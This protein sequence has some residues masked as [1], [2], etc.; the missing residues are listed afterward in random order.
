MKDFFHSRSFK[1]LVAV[2]FILLGLM[3]Y[4][5]SS[6]NSLTANLLGF[7]STPMQ[8]VSTVITNNAVTA[9]DTATRSNEE[10]LKEIDALKKAFRP[11]QVT[12]EAMKKARHDAIFMHCLPAY[13]G[14][15]VTDEVMECAQSVVWDQ[16]ENRMHSIKGILAAVAC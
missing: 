8:K 3:L 6:G 11:Y 5:A 14:V 10:L 9:T 4:T 12:M 15:D 2:V 7:L 16:G 1:L 13:R